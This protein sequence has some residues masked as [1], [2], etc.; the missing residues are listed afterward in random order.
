VDDE[1]LARKHLRIL[2]KAHPEF[3]VTECNNGF[4]AVAKLNAQPA[5][6]V[7]LDIQMPQMNGFEVLAS[8]DSPLPVVI[9]VTA[10]DQFAIRAFEVNA[11][12]Y[13]LKPVD[14]ARFEQALSRAKANLEQKG[15]GELERRLV[16]LL[17]SR[18]AERN[19]PA[20]E[21]T[22]LRRLQVR[23]GPRL[24]FVEVRDIDYIEA[25]DYYSALHVG[26]KTH[27]LRE[28]MK[29]LEAKLD[30]TQFVRVHRSAIVNIRR[31]RELRHRPG[32]SYSVV[33]IDGTCLKLSRARWEQVQAALS[34]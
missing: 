2:L 11:I 1:P 29:D 9:F 30:P 21:P 4:E 12:D 19:Q 13:L 23:S 33:L 5:D 3:E 16:A 7:F 15:L 27:L 18:E 28:P 34:G 17:A 8:L 10:F 6:L 24:L 32:G 31:V 26:A 20:A 14:V 25:N 22:H